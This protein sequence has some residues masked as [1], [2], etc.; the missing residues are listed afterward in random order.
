MLTSEIKRESERS[1]GVREDVR[2][3]VRETRADNRG[4]TRS[5]GPRNGILAPIPRLFLRPGF[6][7]N[8]FENEKFSVK[9]G[10]YTSSLFQARIAYLHLE[11]LARSR[12]WSF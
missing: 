2:R 5:I 3:G 1:M 8:I 11:S 12:R 6:G 10:N 7:Y 4:T 9:Y